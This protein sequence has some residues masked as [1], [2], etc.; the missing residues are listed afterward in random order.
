MQI[1]AA[2]A[3]P[4][5]RYLEHLDEVEGWLSPHSAAFIADLAN[6]Q[7]EL[8]ILGSLGEIGVHMGKLFIL[9]RLSAQ[10]G[11]KC[12][13][14]DV[15]NDQH[16]NVDFSGAASREAFLRNVELWVG[17]AHDLHLI[18]AS[19]L[20]VSPND[21]L[22]EGGRA[23][24]VSVDGGH[25]AEC[26]LNDL[27]LAEGVLAEHGIVVLDDFFNAYWPG[28]ATGATRYLQSSKSRLKPFMIS[29]N[30]IF[31]A[32]SHSHASYRTWMREHHARYF[33]KKSL[34]FDSEV[35]IFLS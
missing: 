7:T 3:H 14:I 18:Q 13:A 21:V 15:F 17:T 19:S 35:D 32:F 24:M 31:L 22:K 23:R 16:L 2:K 27:S 20:T 4:A 1:M 11:E 34:M 5:S 6:L 9:L 12:F 8:G 29:P 30:K 25:T 26:A 10:A 33:S 28:V